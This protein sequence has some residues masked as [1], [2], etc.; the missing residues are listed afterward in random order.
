M[1]F[2]RHPSLLVPGVVELTSTWFL[3]STHP[4]THRA[5]QG[6]GRSCRACSKKRPIT[7]CCVVGPA[8]MG[9][10]SIREGSAAVAVESL[11]ALLLLLLLLLLLCTFLGML[12]TWG[13]R[14]QG[15]SLCKPCKEHSMPSWLAEASRFSLADLRIKHMSEYLYLCVCVYIYT[16]VKPS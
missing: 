8:E 4:R 13:S 12:G 7:R 16:Y 5:I 1:T 11:L 3:T 10:G 9:D 14:I 15:R 2:D 6:L